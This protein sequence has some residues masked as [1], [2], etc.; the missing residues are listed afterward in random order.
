MRHFTFDEAE[1]IL[2][3]ADESLGGFCA[4][5]V[6]EIAVRSPSDIAPA[7]RQE[8]QELAE[9]AAQPN[10]FAE[11]WFVLASLP[12]LAPPR[13]LRLIEARRGDRLIGVALFGIAPHYG[14]APLAHV[15]NWRHHN[16]FF[17]PPLIRG[18]EEISFWRAV[19]AALDMASWA[20]GFLH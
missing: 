3:D 17:G 14:R 7:L 2:A 15:Q 16:H 10:S 6:N 19:L 11:P 13:G 1:R 4:P 8:W 9:S 18:G 12:Q 20:R 5:R